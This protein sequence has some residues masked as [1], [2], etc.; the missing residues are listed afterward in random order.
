MY[1]N[2]KIIVLINQVKN[3]NKNPL[4]YKRGFSAGRRF[5]RFLELGGNSDNF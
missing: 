4:L 2:F 3:I 1:C 5:I